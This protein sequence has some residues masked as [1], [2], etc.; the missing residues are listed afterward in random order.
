MRCLFVSLV[1]ALS[2]AACAT[3]PATMDPSAFNAEMTRHTGNPSAPAADKALS[4]LI[5]R[6]DLSDEQRVDALFLRAEKR[7]AGRFNLPGAIADWDKT[8]T[9]RPEDA[10]AAEAARRKVFAAT[11]IENAQRRLARLQNLSEWFDDK[12]LMGDVAA[13]ANRYRLSGITPTD[14]Q[15]YVLRESGFVCDGA[16]EAVHQIGPMPDYV[17]G[18]VWC[19]DPSLS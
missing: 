10:R 15:L 5:E 17:D 16:G 8:L 12:V 11:E 14:G 3:V 13:A 2:A 18:A 9:L 1:I 7:L 6:T 19:S 4:A